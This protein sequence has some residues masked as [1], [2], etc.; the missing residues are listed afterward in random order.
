MNNSDSEPED[1]LRPEYDFS[2]LK[3][4]VRGKYV[5]RYRA[6]SNIVLL[7]DDVAQAFPD[8]RAVNDALRLL[9]RSAGTQATDEG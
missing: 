6:G 1:D 7:D 4:R 8:A 2:R 3:G 5:E 9:L